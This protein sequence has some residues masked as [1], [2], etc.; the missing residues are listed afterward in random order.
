MASD[1]EVTP[2]AEREFYSIPLV[3]FSGDDMSPFFL[4]TL[5]IC[6]YSLPPLQNG[7]KIGPHL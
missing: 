4:R 3:S 1:D 2:A 6:M 5:N 7:E